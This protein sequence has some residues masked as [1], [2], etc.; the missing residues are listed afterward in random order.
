MNTSAAQR[1]FDCLVLLSGCVRDIWTA[2]Q[3]NEENRLPQSLCPQTKNPML[4]CLYNLQ[5]LRYSVTEMRLNS[6]TLQVN[7]VVRRPYTVFGSKL[8]HVWTFSKMQ[9]NL[10]KWVSDRFPTVGTPTP[11]P[12]HPQPS[13]CDEVY[14]SAYLLSHFSFQLQKSRV[15]VLLI[16]T[17]QFLILLLHNKG[18]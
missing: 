16:K 17:Q 5:C 11:T 2:R 1:H 4:T 15:K 10:Q 8:V 3:L 18:F 9:A 13:L 6:Q 14:M 12:P 7:I